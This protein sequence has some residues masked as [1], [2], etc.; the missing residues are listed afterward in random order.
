MV[1]AQH[2]IPPSEIR[3]VVKELLQALKMAILL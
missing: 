2:P 3:D 1:R